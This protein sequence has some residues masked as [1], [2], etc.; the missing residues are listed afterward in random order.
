MLHKDTGHFRQPFFFGRL[1]PSVS[2]KDV[3]VLI[4][5]A[6]VDEAKFTD[7]SSKLKDLFFA[8]RSGISGIGNE[9]INGNFFK[10]LRHFHRLTPA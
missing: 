9:S 4:D 8:V 10:V 5:Q 6:G 1:Y 7:G 3:V 2:G